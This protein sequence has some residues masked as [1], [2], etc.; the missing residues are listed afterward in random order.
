M[1]VP[2]DYVVSY[3]VAIIATG[4]I[5]AYFFREYSLKKLR[6][7]LAWAV[8]LLLYMITQ[9][10]HLA[11]SM[12]GD[13]AV[14]KPMF[15]ILLIALAVSFALLYYGT[16]Q[17]FFDEES[18]F[19]EKMAILIFLVCL[20]VFSYLLIT[21]P[22]E[23]FADA[24]RLPVEII[25]T[26]LFLTIAALF[27]R[28]FRGLAPDDH[29]RIIILLVSAG[30]FLAAVDTFY[31]GFFEGVSRISDAGINLVHLIAWLLIL[32]GMVLGKATRT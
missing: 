11:S 6:A 20:V 15:A 25:A 16:S 21:V 29:R 30:W 22:T 14:G 4:I 1:N 9:I 7:S 17:L 10:G 27:Y 24:S 28:V 5:S 3:V 8:G 23:G 12:F 18:F 32:Y 26:I 13:I 2:I 31:L 19:R